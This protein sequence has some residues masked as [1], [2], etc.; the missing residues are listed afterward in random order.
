MGYGYIYKIAELY[1]NI[2]EE[3]E[4]MPSSKNNNANY[5]EISLNY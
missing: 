1:H 3:Y 2:K 5:F 4:Y